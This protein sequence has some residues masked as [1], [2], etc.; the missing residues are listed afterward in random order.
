MNDL[1]E[2]EFAEHG[3]IAVRRDVKGQRVV[4]AR[5]YHPRSGD[6]IW[7]PARNGFNW[8]V[9]I[10]KDHRGTPIFKFGTQKVALKFDQKRQMWVI[11]DLLG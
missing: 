2:T 8:P 11:P 10:M 5:D 7:V 1:A 4:C 9:K 6:E 3:C